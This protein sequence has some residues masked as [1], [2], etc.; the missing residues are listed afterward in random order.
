MPERKE[1]YVYIQ[2]ALLNQEVALS[3]KTGWVYCQDKG[4]DGS[5]VSYSPKEIEI[6]EKSGSVITPEIHNVKKV[7]GGTIVESENGNGPGSGD[8]A[9]GNEKPPPDDPDNNKNPPGSV[10]GVSGNGQ[11]NR[12]GELDIY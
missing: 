12:E 6:L 10:P 11:A 4:P 8:T 1:G 5:L 3:L 7:I 2:S 9:G